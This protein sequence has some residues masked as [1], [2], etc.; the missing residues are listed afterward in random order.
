MSSKATWID[1]IVIMG[2]SRTVSEI[3]DVFNRQ[4][5]I[6]FNPV[7]LAPPL[8]GFPL[9]LGIGAW[10]IKTRMMGLHVEKEV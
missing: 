4:S 3:N 9:K 6:S 10:A 5:P 8:K 7:Y 2:L 1:F